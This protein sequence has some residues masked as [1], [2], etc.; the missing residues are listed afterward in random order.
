[1]EK[2]LTMSHRTLADKHSSKEVETDGK[3]NNI[4][5]SHHC[6]FSSPSQPE[7]N[8]HGDELPQSTDSLKGFS[9]K[10]KVYNQML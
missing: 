10:Q 2:Q 1:M 5:T 6:S 3:N 4:I 8:L 9:V 7:V